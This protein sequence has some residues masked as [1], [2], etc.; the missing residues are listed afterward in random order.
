MK[1]LR[2]IL[3]ILFST[4][5]NIPTFATVLENNK[6]SFKDVILDEVVDTTRVIEVNG[7]KEQRFYDEI[8]ISLQCHLTN[9]D[10]VYF[11]VTKLSS[12]KNIKSRK[13]GILLIKNKEGETIEL[14]SFKNLNDKTKLLNQEF[15]Y[16]FL[17]NDFVK[18]HTAKTVFLLKHSINF[19]K[20]DKDD[21][22]KLSKGIKKIKFSLK[23]EKYEKR[24]KHNQLSEI[25]INSK[26][27]I[28]EY[29]QKNQLERFKENF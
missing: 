27:V 9:K 13:D 15:C 23:G 4:I 5:I 8:S 24:F 21:F 26:Q 11:L 6:R 19:W 29:S 2:I 25:I 10:T 16:N 14:H 1:K 20:L 28:E 12:F 22:D 3:L 18:I 17:N 7:W